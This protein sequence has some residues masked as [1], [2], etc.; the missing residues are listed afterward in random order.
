MARTARDAL[1]MAAAAV[2]AA[3]VVAAAVATA[4]MVGKAVETERHG[5]C[6]STCMRF[7]PSC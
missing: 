5:G 4:L 2:V 1:L 6:A 3:S 7:L